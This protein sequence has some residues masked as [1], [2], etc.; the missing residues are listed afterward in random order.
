MLA[1]DIS[2]Y[3]T[4]DLEYY[5]RKQDP[6]WLW[7]KQF[8][9]RRYIAILGNSGYPPRDEL[10]FNCY[11]RITALCWTFDIASIDF[12]D[13]DEAIVEFRALS[14]ELHRVHHSTTL[15]KLCFL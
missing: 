15:F 5:L 10:P 6:G 9:K 13:Y 4:K 2:D 1:K 7:P 14:N 12:I 3:G 11:L 8:S